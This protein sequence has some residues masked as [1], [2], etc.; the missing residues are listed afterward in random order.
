MVTAQA[1]NGVATFSNLAIASTGN[2][3]LIATD[4]SLTSAVSN[5][6][7]IGPTAFVNF[8]AGATTFT[9]QF[10][11]NNQGNP[12]GTRTLAGARLMGL[13]TRQ[14]RRPA[15]GSHPQA[16]A[17]IRP[18]FTPRRL[19]ICRMGWSI[20]FPNS[21]PRRPA[22]AV[23]TNFCR[24]ASSRPTHRVSIPI[25]RSFPPAFLAIRPSSSSQTTAGSSATSIDNTSVTGTINTGDW[26]QL[27]FTTDE[28]AS[29][30]FQGT[31]SVLDY[32][33]TGVSAPTT[34]L[35]AVPYSVTGLTTL[36][37]ASAVYAGFRSIVVESLAHGALGFDNFAVDQPPSVPTVSI[38]PA[39]K[40]VKTGNSTS[41][42]AAA[43][44]NS[45][46]SVQWQ[47]ST[48]GGATF[49]NLSNGGVYSGVTTETLSISNTSNLNGN[50]Y[51][52]VFSNSA[53]IAASTAATLSLTNSSGSQTYPKLTTQPANPTI[54]NA[55]NNVTITAAASGKGS[56][57]NLTVQWNVSTDGGLTFSNLTNGDGTYS[58]TATVNSSGNPVSDTLTIT[59]A[60]FGL[61]GNV[62][63]AVF[64]NSLGSASSGISTL[65]VATAPA[66][67][68][69]PSSQTVDIGGLV[70]FTAAA[71]GN[72]PP[73]VQ[74]QV[75]T[76]GGGAWS[77]I[78][79]ATSATL[80]FN[81]VS[82]S[83]AGSEYR[84]I[85]TNSVSTATTNAATLTLN[86]NT[87]VLS[88]PS[89]PAPPGAPVTFTAMIAGSPSV[90]TVSFYVGSVTPDNQIGS[91]VN[92][93]GG[94]ATSAA[95]SSLSPGNETIIAV[96][97]GGTGF[98][99]S[100]A[101]M[102][103]TINPGLP[104]SS[105]VALP[106]AESSAS[107]T[108]TWSGQDY[109]GGSGVAD[110]EVYVS[111]DGGPV[112]LFESN[113]TATS[114]TFTGE[115]GHTYSFY[116]VATDIGGN[117]QATPTT[118]QATTL[119]DLPPTAIIVSPGANPLTAP[120]DQLT[121]SFS[122]PVAGLVLADLSL[123][124]NGGA[125]SLRRAKHS[126]RAMAK[127]ICWEI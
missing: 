93:S 4:S 23:A 87:A 86:T 63:D 9:S 57:G 21:S 83:Q 121:L 125:I 7:Y 107:F 41:F 65:A 52:A 51:Q 118:A 106:A 34:V 8:N 13:T 48:N 67:T 58:W 6:F 15:A 10:A 76:N 30:N 29:G 85:F 99:G 44:G 108:V 104:T 74:W 94:T 127:T 22:L 78:N 56:S 1:V 110:Y 49:T 102:S 5:G 70:T 28:T 90:G 17:P 47:V 39:N 114:A 109:V 19:S 37:T 54:V 64:T 84:A 95:V 2:Y 60:T 117:Q 38:S 25:S 113:T 75:S 82:A 46:Q 79:G 36:G 31:F 91:A 14:E 20:R 68:M 42:F 40:T 81:S 50:L 115:D 116:S 35:A 92:V 43:S 61:N 11:L 100:Q 88:A 89:S 62:Y 33:P 26:L 120:V 18:P 105:V 59:G 111:D 66:V 3:T 16:A 101:T 122:K 97:S 77:N 98:L 69:Q 32:G 24:S 112:A 55:G 27:I 119:V 124:L 80:T 71:S 96:Y 126:P 123:T 45:A 73:T 103:I 12:G 53:G 72:A